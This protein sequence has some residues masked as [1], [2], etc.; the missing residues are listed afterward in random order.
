MPGVCA[1]VSRENSRLNNEHSAEVRESTPYLRSSLL[2]Q[3]R[4]LGAFQLCN[5]EHWLLTSIGEMGMFSS[6]GPMVVAAR[7][8]NTE[9]SLIPLW[10]SST[11]VQFANCLEL[12]FCYFC[13]ERKEVVLA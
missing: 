13:F 1:L 6:S 8:A 3:S 2:M 10:P 5:F 12:L 7:Y 4:G 11:F 9:V